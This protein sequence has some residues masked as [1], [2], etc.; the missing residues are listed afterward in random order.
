MGPPEPAIM[1]APVPVLNAAQMKSAAADQLDSLISQV[2]GLRRAIC[3]RC[4][5][6]K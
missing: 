3:V 1:R 5:Y 4:L 6:A 2:K